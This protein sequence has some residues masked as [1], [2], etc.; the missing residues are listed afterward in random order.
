MDTF[1]RLDDICVTSNLNELN[2]TTYIRHKKKRFVND[3]LKEEN[4]FKILK[5]M[6]LHILWNILKY[7]KHIKYR[8]INK[9]A[10]YNKLFSKCH[11]LGTDFEQI[12]I[13]MEVHL[14]YYG[15]RQGNDNNWYYQHYPIQLLH[16]WK[17]YQAVITHQII[18]KIRHWIKG[19]VCILS[20]GKWKDYESVFD[21]EHRTIMLFDKN[22]LKIKSLQLGNPNKSSLEFNVHIQY[23]NDIDIHQTR[24]KWACLILNHTW[25]FRTSH[26]L[27]RDDLS[28]CLSEFGS[29]HVIWKDIDKRIHKESL[30]PYSTT[31]KQG[32]QHV[33]HKLL[34]INHFICGTDELIL[35][36]C[37]FDKWKPSIL[38][39]MNDSD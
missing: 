21:Y 38:L 27:D 26:P 6:H 39:N 16:L 24:A 28:N 35:F 25:H 32:I 11:T 5:N 4:E 14:Q 30:N 17:C 36:E 13:S 29:F 20:N 12:F 8:Q 19:S 34:M 2:D 7:P 9:Q 37:I 23:Y 10:L 31:L 18:Y 22:K 1:V 33:R 15:F 3:R